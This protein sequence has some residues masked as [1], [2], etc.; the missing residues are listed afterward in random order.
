[1]R[2]PVETPENGMGDSVNKWM[3]DGGDKK[4]WD[5]EWYLQRAERP[6]GV[7]GLPVL[8]TTG[9]NMISPLLAAGPDAR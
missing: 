4:A 9:V 7:Q 1:M 3:G 2:G 6:Y 5:N 8:C